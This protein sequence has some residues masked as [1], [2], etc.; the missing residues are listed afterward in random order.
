MVGPVG[1]MITIELRFLDFDLRNKD[2]S[3][4]FMCVGLAE[5]NHTLVA[6]GEEKGCDNVIFSK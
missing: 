5:T 1:M 6:R 3:S 2:Q 4:I